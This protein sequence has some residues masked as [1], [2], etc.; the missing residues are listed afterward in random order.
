MELGIYRG[1]A[2]VVGFLALFSASGRLPQCARCFA[3]GHLVFFQGSWL[4][5]EGKT[6]RKRTILVVVCG[7]GVQRY[8]F[9]VTAP[10]SMDP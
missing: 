9:F 5:V 8:M 10:A 6:V 3:A 7:F 4:G 1:G 2:I